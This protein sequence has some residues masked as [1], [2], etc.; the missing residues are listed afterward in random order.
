MGEHAVATVRSGSTPPYWWWRESI[1]E[2]SFTVRRCLIPL[3]AALVVYF[4]ALGVVFFGDIIELLGTLD[5]FGGVLIQASLREE[6]VWVTGMIIAGVGGSA[7]CSDLAARKIRGELDALTVLSVDL[8]RALVV[9]RVVGSTVAACILGMLAIL[10]IFAVG[11][12][13]AVTAHGTPAAAYF[14][15]VDLFT[16]TG[17]VLAFLL[18][19][20]VIGAFVAVV[21]TYKGLHAAAGPEGV[22]RAVNQTVLITFVAVWVFNVLFNLVLMALAPELVVFRG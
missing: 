14:V 17:D 21:A 20:A 11:L 7:M 12:V 3:T 1:V 16:L 10:I 22:G 5:R 18:K 2:V 9:P 19:M 8:M 6:A 15:N 13:G 4:Y